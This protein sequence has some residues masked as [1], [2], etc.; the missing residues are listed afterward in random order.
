MIES[1][2][3]FQSTD[4]RSIVATFCT[5]P[6]KLR[7]TRHSLGED[8]V[9]EPILDTE[10]FLDS[11]VGTGLDPFLSG[12][13]VKYDIGYF[14]G[15]V[16]SEQ[17]RSNSITCNCFLEVEPSFAKKF[18]MHMASV[19][20]IF[21]FACAPDER[22]RR[23]RVTVKQGVNTIESWV[24]RD[25]QKYVPGFYWLTLL[26][27]ALAEKYGVPLSAVE[28]NAKEHI[29]LKGG[30]HI[31]RFYERPEDWQATSVVAELCA[32]LPGVF[33]VEKVKP[34]LSAAK[35]FLDLNAV[36]RNWK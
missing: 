13:C 6:E 12:A 5:L 20:P 31:F 3:E 11:L 1:T 30:Q 26:P 28:K 21:G 25:T 17:I 4:L 23:N 24:G 9:G 34:Q 33:D 16:G 29:D 10:K 8:E 2:L 15:F 32:S 27:E 22:V 35:N 18:L 36:L 19:H 7:P 14:D